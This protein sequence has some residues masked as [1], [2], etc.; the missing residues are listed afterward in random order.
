MKRLIF[1]PLLLF[2]CAAVAA[3]PSA[4]SSADAERAAG[5]AARAAS[6]AARAGDQ[7]ERAAR[8]AARSGNQAARAGADAAR[9][10]ADAQ[11]LAE[12]QAHMGDLAQRMAEL[13]AKI[14]DQ[15]SASALRYLADDKSGMLGIAIDPDDDGMHV[16]AVT[17]GGP[18]E[19]AGL[20]TGDVI[21]AINGKR[22]SWSDSSLLTGLADLPAGKPVRLTVLRNGKTL[23]VHA[24]PERLQAGDWQATVRAA[25]RAAR[26]ATASLRSPEFSKR[27]QA[28]V[29]EAVRNASRAASA[30]MQAQKDAG[31]AWPAIAPWW[32][33]NLAPLNPGLGRYFGTDEGALVL[34]RDAQ[35]YPD[36]QPGD[37][38][39]RVGGH[40]VQ[41]PQDAVR[42]F[43]EAAGGQP[44]AVTVQRHHK[45]LKLS[46]K[47][48]PRSLALPPPPPALA[49]AAPPAP[50][51]APPPPPPAAPA[52]PAPPASAGRTR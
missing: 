34:S 29:A 21:T 27:I 3:P 33:L 7:A 44:L 6:E 46:F 32:G 14:G 8:E 37:V 17:P 12:L 36:L 26:Q 39:M 22:L 52:P 49:P 15:A 20:K 13:S 40:P 50:P 18:A 35:R 28:Q 41:R 47:S 51:A 10:A 9:E 16:Q 38:I 48:P 42:A 30:A 2:A 24:T 5:D 19:R 4:S 23:H 31:Y 43:R 25:E 11:R 1:L 45:T